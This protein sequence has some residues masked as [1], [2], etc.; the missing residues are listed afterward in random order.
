MV[1]WM[2]ENA[3][4]P[5]R[6][7]VGITLCLISLVQIGA[8]TASMPGISVWCGPGVSGANSIA[9]CWGCY[10][11]AFGFAL[12]GIETVRAFLISRAGAGLAPS[13]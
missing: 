3:M 1:A 11:L 13:S 6:Y 4:L 8:H 7:L 5:M 10:T 12:I 2:E 9:H